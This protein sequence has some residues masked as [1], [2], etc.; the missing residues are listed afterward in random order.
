M[1]A[2]DYNPEYFSEQI[3]VMREKI[4]SLINKFIKY[5]VLVQTYPED[6]SYNNEHNLITSEIQTIKSSLNKASTTMTNLMAEIRQKM[7]ILNKKIKQEKKHYSTLK[8]R[9]NWASN[10]NTGSELLYDDYQYRYNTQILQNIIIC[11]GILGMIKINHN[12][13][14]KTS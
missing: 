8:K 7:E 13:L 9:H 1:S 2:L 4:P 10:T 12:L 3:Q 11:I 14:K 5:D 6:E